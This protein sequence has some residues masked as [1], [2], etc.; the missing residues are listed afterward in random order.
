MKKKIFFTFMTAVLTSLAM[1]S[2]GNFTQFKQS[3]AKKYY[4]FTDQ[5]TRKND[6]YH[7][8]FQNEVISQSLKIIY[9][10]LYSSK[11]I[12]EQV[13]AINSE[14]Y[15]KDLKFKLN[16]YN[17]INSKASNSL[18]GNPNPLLF[19]QAFNSYGNLFENNWLWF[20]ANIKRSI[21]IRGIKEADQFLI[22]HEDSNLK[23]KEDAL[24]SSFYQPI[25]NQFKD[26]ALVLKNSNLNPENQILTKEY[27]LYLLNSENFIFSINFE[28]QFKDN[29][30]IKVNATLSPWI[31]IYPKFLNKNSLQFPLQ[32]YAYVI[33]NFRSGKQ[34]VSVSQPEKSFFEEKQGGSRYFYTLI[35]FN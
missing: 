35:D 24:N 10:D 34:G 3:L 18:L 20:L 33:S 29:K 16:F 14:S 9:S 13:D 23:L 5:E 17:T 15:Q 27:E 26:M 2:C 32:E 31:S 25:S 6:N 7:H 19:Q 12:I 11:E 1:V 4:N 21:F 28:Q 30:L 22:L 8:F